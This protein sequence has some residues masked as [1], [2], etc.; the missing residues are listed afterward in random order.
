MQNA[1]LRNIILKLYRNRSPYISIVSAQK[2]IKCKTM[3]YFAINNI[4]F[5]HTILSS[6]NGCHDASL[7]MGAYWTN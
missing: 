5:E 6:W 3:H 1:K 4:I 2:E 7:A